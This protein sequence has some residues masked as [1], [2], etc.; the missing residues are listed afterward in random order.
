MVILCHYGQMSAVQG[1]QEQLRALA[2]RGNDLSL[3][4]RARSQ[5]EALETMPAIVEPV[6][7]CL[8][9][10]FGSIGA[11]DRQWIRDDPRTG[12]AA[13]G[14]GERG[15]E[16]GLSVVGSVEV[17]EGLSCVITCTVG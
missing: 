16:Q 10:M 15:G 9:V 1:V 12:P 7:L 17:V 11:A 3:D 4:R 6:Q 2:G 14:G 5:K 8:C 13:G